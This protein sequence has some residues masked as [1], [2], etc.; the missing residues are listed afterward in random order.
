M[1]TKKCSV[2]PGP[3][4]SA[5]LREGV[6]RRKVRS[7]RPSEADEMAP[8]RRYDDDPVDPGFEGRVRLHDLGVNIYEEWGDSD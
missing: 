8:L 2:I 4:V 1:A 3:Y 5:H 7:R 6:T